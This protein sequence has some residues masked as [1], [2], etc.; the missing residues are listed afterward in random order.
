MA[1]VYPVQIVCPFY[2]R[3]DGRHITCEGVIPD[4]TMTHFFGAADWGTQV[5]VFCCDKYEN[6]EAYMAV[7]KK[8]EEAQE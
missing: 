4:T 8:Y 6:C 1:G 5:R 7:M 2:R 3:S